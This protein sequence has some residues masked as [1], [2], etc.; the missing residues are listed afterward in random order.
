MIFLAYIP[1][2]SPPYATVTNDLTHNRLHHKHLHPFIATIDFVT[3]HLDKRRQRRKK[4]LN[5]LGVFRR[6]R[7]LCI[8]THKGALCHRFR[9]RV[10]P[11]H[12]SCDGI[13]LRGGRVEGKP[14]TKFVTGIAKSTAWMKEKERERSERENEM[15]CKEF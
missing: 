6:E 14:G 13:G 7:V 2:P 10:L 11:L 5:R 15:D 8:R 12:P 4:F 1:P 3:N 9:F